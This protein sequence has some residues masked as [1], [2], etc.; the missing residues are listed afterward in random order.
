MKEY[1]LGLDQQILDGLEIGKNFKW[2]REIKSFSKI[3]YCGL[4]GSAI[5]GDIIRKLVFKKGNYPFQVN[6]YSR[7]P[8]WVDRDTLVILTSY[9]GNTRETLEMAAEALKTKA[10]LLVV[11]SGG[12]LKQL[13]KR[14]QIPYIQIPGGLP[15]RC[16]TGYITFSLMV[17]LQKKRF[18]KVTQAELNEVVALVRKPPYA[19]AR[20]LAQKMHG[21]YVHF[22]AAN[23]LAAPAMMRFKTQLAENSKVLAS[24]CLLPEMFHNEVE[25][26]VHP[27]KVIQNSTA[28]FIE[29]KS[30]PA[31]IHKKAV[32]AQK[33]FKERGADV[34]RIKSQG[35]SPLGRLFYLIVLADWLS[36]ALAD[37]EGVDPLEI[38]TISRIKKI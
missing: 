14:K 22:Y 30:D 26:W 4:G 15:P 25:G 16:A 23:G 1:L 38:P 35:K 36:L 12:K 2:T 34:I 3:L 7:I 33:I 28:V 29:D 27:K 21:R 10:S 37:I 13:A 9:S 6:R 32:A 17:V 5:S 11:T 18:L 24:M 19:K 20:S 8:Q 31:W